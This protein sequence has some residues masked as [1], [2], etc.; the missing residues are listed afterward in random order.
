MSLSYLGWNI[1]PIPCG[2]NTRQT[3]G[4]GRVR[5]EISTNKD[6][7]ISQRCR[8]FEYSCNIGFSFSLPTVAR[9]QVTVHN[10]TNE[11]RNHTMKS[12]NKPTNSKLIR[13]LNRVDD[14]SLVAKC[15]NSTMLLAEALFGLNSSESLEWRLR[16]E[17]EVP[18]LFLEVSRQTTGFLGWDSGLLSTNKS[19]R[20]R[21]VTKAHGRIKV[22]NTRSK[23]NGSESE[24]RTLTRVTKTGNKELRENSVP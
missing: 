1:T 18:P 2:K 5:L 24:V 16:S 9:R 13:N 15:S 21:E 22:S 7:A 20:I 4:T 11:I 14:T 3:F 6:W 8:K 23:I 19:K 10:N 12:M 17:C